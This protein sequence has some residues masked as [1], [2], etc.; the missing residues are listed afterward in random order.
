MMMK[1]LR[2]SLDVTI[3]PRLLVVAARHALAGYQRDAVLPRLLGLG[4]RDCVSPCAEV[5]ETLIAQE[6]ALDQARR[7]HATHWRAADHVLLMAALLHEAELLDMP[8]TQTVAAAQIIPLQ[9]VAV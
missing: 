6:A 3:R 7:Q 4:L 5:L 9:L 8:A 2:H 1:P